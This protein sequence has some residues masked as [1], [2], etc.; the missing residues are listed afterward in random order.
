[1]PGGRR[2]AL[3]HQVSY[4]TNTEKSSIFCDFAKFLGPY[5]SIRVHNL[6]FN[7]MLDGPRQN[8]SICKTGQKCRNLLSSQRIWHKYHQKTKKA[9]KN[10]QKSA[11]NPSRRDAKNRLNFQR[12]G[13]IV[14]NGITDPIAL[15]MRQS[16]RNHKR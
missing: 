11:K 15:Q 2:Q 8:L 1:M 13:T 7:K 16:Q 6:L 3:F 9:Q 5:A 14:I 10:N 12:A 4:Q